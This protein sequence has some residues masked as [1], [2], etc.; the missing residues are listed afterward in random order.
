MIS[1]DCC[2]FRQCSEVL[3]AELIILTVPCL[4]YLLIAEEAMEG[5]EATANCSITCHIS[6]QEAM[7]PRMPALSVTV[8]QVRGRSLVYKSILNIH[9]FATVHK[10]SSRE[11]MYCNHRNSK[12]RTNSSSYNGMWLVHPLGTPVLQTRPQRKQRIR[13]LHR[14]NTSPPRAR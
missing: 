12:C 13:C 8:F 3:E 4:I 6:S 5:D 11:S 10:R 9:N 14:K 1:L 7:V 2:R